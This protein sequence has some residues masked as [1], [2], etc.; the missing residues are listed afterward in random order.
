MNEHETGMRRRPR[1]SRGAQ[2]VAAILDAAEQLYGE[3]G[4][5]ATSTNE[6]ATRANTSIGSLYQ[7]FPN[8]EAILHG[9]AERYRAGF[10]TLADELFRPEQADLPLAELVGRLLDTMIAYGGEH[11]GLIRVI[12]QPGAPQPIAAAARP[13]YA[14]LATRLEQLLEQRAPHLSVEQRTLAA[15]VSITTTMA[16]IAQ[17][18]SA[19]IGGRYEHMLAIFGQL[20]V[21]LVAYIETVAR[22]PE[23][24]IRPGAHSP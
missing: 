11:L 3:L 12:L 13:M 20:R 2:R 18:I 9:V 21:L 15:E 19:K 22:S 4:Y 14:E 10:A 16:L 6:I 7:F 8:K 5:E 24:A 1:Q 17:A 23:L